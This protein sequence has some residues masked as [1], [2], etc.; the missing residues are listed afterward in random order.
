MSDKDESGAVIPLNKR[1]RALLGALFSI[2]CFAHIVRPTLGID[3]V[4]SGL[5]V[6]AVALV[7]FDIDGFEWKGLKARRLQQRVD[8]AEDIVAA[9]TVPTEQAAP[10]ALPD[11][12]S[13]QTFGIGF[14]GLVHQSTLELT[15]PVDPLERLLW[16]YEQIRIELIVLSGNAG[17]LEERVTFDR[18]QP[19]R[20][21]KALIAG[22][23]LPEKLAQPIDTVSRL[24]NEVVHSTTRLTP[25]LLESSSAL[26]VVSKLAKRDQHAGRIEKGAVVLGVCCRTA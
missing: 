22:S 16:A 9:V 10:P 18:Y 15:P 4:S 23:R 17:V 20:L 6:A 7:F 21:A 14:Q 1:L 12:V 25:E 5:L 19:R 13:H 26:E 3:A 24:R 8:Q 2:L 11:P